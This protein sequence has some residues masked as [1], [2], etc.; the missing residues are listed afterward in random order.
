[1]FMSCQPDTCMSLTLLAVKNLVLKLTWNAEISGKALGLSVFF[2]TACYG[3]ASKYRIVSV[4][5]AQNNFGE[6]CFF[7]ISYYQYNFFVTV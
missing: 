6:I 5:F 4:H 3:H 7:S 2:R 1:V